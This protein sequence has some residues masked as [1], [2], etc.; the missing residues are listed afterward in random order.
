MMRSLLLA[1][2]GLLVADRAAA[3]SSVISVADFGAVGDGIADD[4]AAI[5]AAITAAAPGD[6]VYFPAGIYSASQSVSGPW[7]ILVNKSITLRGA[8]RDS[9]TLMLDKIEAASVDTS[10]LLVIRASGVVVEHLAL[11]GN[12]PGKGA[13]T[14]YDP[15]LEHHHG[16]QTQDAAGV[17]VRDVYVHDF[18]GDGIQ[19]YLNTDAFTIT[20]STIRWCQR[21]GISLA[22]E[23]VE[24]AT[25]ARVTIDGCAGQC[26]DNEHGPANDVEISES[27]LAPGPNDNFTIGMSGEDMANPSYRWNI[28]DNVIN[29]AIF[30]VWTQNV[31]IERNTGVSQSQHAIIE[32]SRSASHWVVRNNNWRMAQTTLAGLAAV[33]LGGTVGSG[34]EDILIEGNT[35]KIDHPS[36]FGV[37]ADGAVSVTV[38]GNDFIGAGVAAPGFYGVRIRATVEARDFASAVIE[39]NRIRDFGQKGVQLSGSGA[40]KILDVRIRGNAFS[41]TSPIGPSMMTAISLDDGTGAAKSVTVENNVR[42]CGVAT[43]VANIPLGVALQASPLALAQ[44]CP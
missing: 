29:G 39:G 18:T 8:S 22:A 41:N 6:V 12:K 30:G 33:Y 27:T 24:G 19:L 5:Q 10:H 28:H 42:G 43:E 4:R 35:F 21:D 9:A 31:T 11:D 20:D 15:L 14:G 34:S 1:A 37:R 13:F 32:L 2:A 38:R 36:T 7:S 44:G 3:T 25:I 16:I 23:L 26:I 40:A 17:I